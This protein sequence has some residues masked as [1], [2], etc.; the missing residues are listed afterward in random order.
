MTTQRP[1][2]IVSPVGSEGRTVRVFRYYD[3]P[4]S[5][6]W[7]HRLYAGCWDGTLDE[8]TDRIRPGGSHGWACDVE[9]ACRAEYAAVIDLARPQVAAWSVPLTD[10]ERAAR[11][12]RPAGI[13]LAGAYLTRADLTGA[14]L[15]GAYLAGAN[16][17]DA[18]LA[19]AYLA[20]AY[21]ADADLTRVRYDQSTRWPDGI[22]P[23]TRGAVLA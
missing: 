18:Y 7:S 17:A 10:A 13:D 23:A 2:L 1:Y 3:G 16:L 15:A 8:L 11:E 12:G 5:T 6:S 21:L 20:G 9:A 22:D 4:D 14:N 19:G